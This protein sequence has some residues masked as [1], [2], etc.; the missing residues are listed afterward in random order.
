MKIQSFFNPDSA[1][2][3]IVY[4]VGW[5][6][7]TWKG[8]SWLA[9]RDLWAF[10]KLSI[11]SAIMLCLEIWYFMSII[12]LTGHLEDPVLA[13]GSLSIWYKSHLSAN[14]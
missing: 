14:N 5:C 10:L 8:M 11:A 3:Q 9:F 12:V 7:D 6:Q 4:I 13:V 1:S 2:S